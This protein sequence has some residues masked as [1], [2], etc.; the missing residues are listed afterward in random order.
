M[1][2]DKD[3]CYTC[4]AEHKPHEPCIPRRAEPKPEPDLF[5]D[6]GGIE[7]EPIEQKGMGPAFPA[8]YDG[9][10]SGC[11]GPIDRGDQIR[12]D[13]QGGWVQVGPCEEL[14]R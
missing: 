7:L 3:F 4:M 6:A 10:C 8:E 9:E 2:K 13:G 12:A 5:E 1:S 11:G 14:F